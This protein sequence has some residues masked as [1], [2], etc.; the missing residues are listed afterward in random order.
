MFD[1]LFVLI[2]L[3]SLSIMVHSY[4]AKCV[5][6]GYIHMGVDLF[7]LDFYLDRVVPHQPWHQKTRGTAVV[8]TASF[9]VSCY[10][11]N[12]R[13]WQTE[14]RTDRQ[15]DMPPIAQLYSACKASFVVHFNKNNKQNMN[16]THWQLSWPVTITITNYYIIKIHIQ[17]SPSADIAYWPATPRMKSMWPAIAERLNNPGLGIG[18]RVRIRIR[19]RVRFRVMVRSRSGI[20]KVCMRDFKIAQHNLQSVQLH[21]SRTTYPHLVLLDNEHQGEQ[22]TTELYA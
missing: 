20:C 15:T 4:E 16:S 19:I 5:Q 1:F 6:L 8:K 3:F 18:F 7:V 17:T 2:E 21:K 13:V 22:H 9:Y 10:W 12:T 14:R 11:Y